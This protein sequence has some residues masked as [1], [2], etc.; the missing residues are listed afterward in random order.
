[1]DSQETWIDDQ[2]IYHQHVE[3]TPNLQTQYEEIIG[4]GL[5]IPK[6]NAMTRIY[7]QNTNGVSV[8]KHG[9]LEVILEQ[10]RHMEVDILIITET[11]LATDKSK[12]R[13]Q[14]YNTFRRT[15]GQATHRLVTATSSQEYPGSYKP[16]GVMG[17]VIG[18]TIARVIASGHD[19][20]GRWV[21]IKLCEM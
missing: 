15:F 19:P 2:S 17:A 10:V 18:K 3:G 13:T 14:I 1:M 12:I 21:F 6:S 8:G 20:L 16:G 11:N 7:C 4:D 9:D 5:I